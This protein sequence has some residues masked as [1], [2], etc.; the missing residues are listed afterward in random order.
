MTYVIHHCHDFLVHLKE[1]VV[2][3]LSCSMCEA[4]QTAFNSW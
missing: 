4:L 3:Q 2:C 1:A